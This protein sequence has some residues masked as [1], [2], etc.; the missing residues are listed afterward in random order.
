[1]EASAK[2]I[3]YF[4]DCFLLTDTLHLFLNWIT[5]KKYLITVPHIHTLK[6]RNTEDHKYHKDNY[7]C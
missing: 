7:F 2:I 4:A 5:P 3:K 1:M 6:L